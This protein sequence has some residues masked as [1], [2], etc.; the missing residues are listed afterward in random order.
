MSLP[1]YKILGYI[2]RYRHIILCIILG[3]FWLR[4]LLFT[5][6]THTKQK[7][8]L[9]VIEWLNNFLKCLGLSFQTMI[10]IMDNNYIG[11]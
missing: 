4:V 2:L 10:L 5:P 11:L 6:H 1:N 9:M 3:F 7:N 8:Q